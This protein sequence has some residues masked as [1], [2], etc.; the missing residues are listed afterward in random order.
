MR[1]GKIVS[2]DSHLQYR[3]QVYTR[4]EAEPCPS[5]EDFG[6]GTYVRVPLGADPPRSLVGIVYDTLLHNPDY[7]AFSPR[8][9]SAEDLPVF[10]PD[11]LDET[12]TLVSIVVVGFTDGDRCC[13]DAPAA[14]PPVNSEVHGMDPG[15]VCLFHRNGDEV[16]LGYLPLLI[17]IARTNPVMTQTILRVVQSLQELF[18]DGAAG[19]RLRLVRQN[20]SWQ[21]RVLSLP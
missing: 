19:M 18:P 17:A 6:L 8:L 10:S 3:C 9:S 5:P 2:S 7:G 11:Y 4:H 14:A 13:H 1:L 20:L 16:S 21:F 15:E 12:R